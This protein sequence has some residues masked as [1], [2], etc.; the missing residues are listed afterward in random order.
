MIYL[1]YA[2][3]TPICPEILKTY[4]RLLEKHYGNSDS[5]HELG[6]ETGKLMEQSRA[7][8][9]QLLHVYKDEILFTSCASESNNAA[10]KGGSLEICQSR[11]ASDHHLCGAFQHS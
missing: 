6:R 8:I 2:S 3:T 1:D 11:Q 5:L 7:Q 4:T 10:I 9:A